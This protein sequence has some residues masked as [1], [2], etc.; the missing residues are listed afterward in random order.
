VLLSSTLLLRVVYYIFIVVAKLVT[1]V[2]RQQKWPH[3][4][5]RSSI[6]LRKVGALLTKLTHHIPKD[7]NFHGHTN[8]NVKFRRYC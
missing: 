7:S 6:F 4:E 8:G 2:F 3:P 1:S 5:H